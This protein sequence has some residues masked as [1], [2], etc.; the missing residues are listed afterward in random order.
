MDVKVDR[1]SPIEVKLSVVIPAQRVDRE[2]ERAYAELRRETKL[3]GFRK[4]RVPRKV[5][6]EQ[7]GSEVADQVAATLAGEA[8][9]HAVEQHQL[10]PVGEP[11]ISRGRLVA[12][13][14]FELE[15]TVQV[16]PELGAVDIDRLELS[17][18]DV[19]VSDDEVDEQLTAMREQQQQ[20][21]V[22]AEDRAVGPGDVADVTLTL[23]ADGRDDQVR[24]HVLVG[25]P[26]D[27]I[28]AFL[29][30]V[31]QGLRRGQSRTAEVVVSADFVDEAWAGQQCT[32][33]V[34]LEDIQVLTAPALDDAFAQKMGLADV[35]RLREAVR[36]ELERAKQQRARA[37]TERSAVET[38]VARHPF[39]V[40][41]KLVEQRARTLVAAIGAQLAQDEGVSMPASLEDLNDDKR[42]DVMAEAAFSARRELVLEA[43]AAQQGLEA[44]D[45]DRDAH[46]QRIA[47]QTGKPASLIR[48][49]LEDQ[50]EMPA[51]DA[52]IA[53]EK[54]LEL[55]LERA[56]QSSN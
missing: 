34:C 26:S 44:N 40:P 54:A 23:S 25:L 51:L 55:L 43:I 1:T 13:R 16:R 38:I 48:S 7:F 22:V 28:F 19:D 17:W 27:L 4:G 6:A 37:K 8:V 18:G 9:G 46:I 24:E 49:Y 35:A 42:A 50:G 5:L 21:V 3:P 12:K 31:V 45:D 39:E 29:L 53:E 47:Q 52:R 2:L 15:A 30:D 14:A 41:S 32:A 33:T 11:D 10:R 56:K 20:L 36:E